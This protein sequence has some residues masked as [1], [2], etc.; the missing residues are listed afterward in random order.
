M[1]RDFVFHN[2]WQEISQGNYVVQYLSCDHPWQHNTGPFGGR[3]N[4]TRGWCA[5]TL[6]IQS[7]SDN[8]SCHCSFTSSA[9]LNGTLELFNLK[10]TRSELEAIHNFLNFL[11]DALERKKAGQWERYKEPDFKDCW[12]D[13][14]GDVNQNPQ[15]EEVR[16]YKRIKE[17]EEEAKKGG[18]RKIRM[19]TEQDPLGKGE[20]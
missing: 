19:R 10:N 9:R 13:E 7:S 8:K 16:R 6:W 4:I 17:K 1:L 18:G 15:A 14:N 3:T 11:E 2:I 12:Y 20:A 5:A